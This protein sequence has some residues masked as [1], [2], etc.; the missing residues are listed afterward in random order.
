[1]CR[2]IL[3]VELKLINRERDI[4]VAQP[5]TQKISPDEVV[6][7]VTAVV[8]SSLVLPVSALDISLKTS[9]GSW[10]KR[11]K[12]TVGKFVDSPKNLGMKDEVTRQL[13]AETAEESPSQPLHPTCST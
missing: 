4:K 10:H 12:S 6:D 11:V 1:M 13:S 2:C 5:L 9:N 3:Y 7:N 8:G